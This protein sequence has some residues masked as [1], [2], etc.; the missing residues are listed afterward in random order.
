MVQIMRDVGRLPIS[1]TFRDLLV[2]VVV[3]VVVGCVL[4]VVAA[5]AGNQSE[6]V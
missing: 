3:L 6:T 4:V 2:D 1:N 5:A